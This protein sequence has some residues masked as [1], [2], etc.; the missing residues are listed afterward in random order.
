MAWQDI[1]TT[2]VDAKSPL[3]DQLLGKIRGNLYDLD[4]RVI[5]A[6]NKL[7]LFELQG[8]L[9]YLSG[10][11]RS[12]CAS[13]INDAFTPARVRWVLKKS[14]TSGTLAFDV[15][16][17]TSPNTPITE[18]AHQYNAATQSIAQTGSA[19]N[20][21]SIA[22]FVS[23]ISTQ[24]ITHAKAAKN[25][26][27]IILLGYVESLGADCVQ[28]NLDATI[29][30]DTVVGDSFVAASASDSNNNGT[31]VIVEK[32][33]GGGA[34]VV[35]RNAAG[36][37]Q[38]GAAGTIQEKIMSYNFTNPVSSTGFVAG[39]AHDFASHTSSANDGDL[40]VY[41]INQ[42]GNN[43]WVKN[44]VGVTQGGVAGTVDTNFW[45]FA[46]SGAASTT[47]YIVGEYAKTASHS[48]G[49]NNAGA[50]KIIAV[51][52]GGNNL[53]LY[54]TLGVVQAGV[55]GNINTN[56]WTYA[57]PSDPSAQVTAGDTMYMLGHTNSLNDGTFTIKEVN[58]SASN[59]VVVYNE[60]GVAQGGT[61]GNVYTTRKLVKFSSDQSAV[62]ATSSYVEL[63]GCVDSTYNYKATRAPY[64]VLQVN[65]GGGANFN[66]VIDVPT[67]AAQASPAGRVHL[68]MRSLFNT[69]PSFSMSVTG[70]EPNQNVTGTS[71]DL[72]AS[73]I[74]AGTPLHLYIT[75]Y[76]SGDPR[77]LTIAFI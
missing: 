35:I 58:R 2:E 16:K 73:S 37:A 1:A 32:N 10:H 38:T 29:D 63:E 14:G 52:S 60:S 46:L 48:S 77:D 62:Y 11:Y 42:S 8:R 17:H 19:L 47:D 18:I 24:S 76:P 69:A 20:T 31:F 67:G 64:R 71:T 56:R 25:I 22:R 30:S 43:I 7:F 54:N 59:N 12:I 53:V 51:N 28:Y 36:V 27:S 4:S 45:T 33:R 50:L 9:S 26:Q 66:I 44:P 21:Q 41:A 61:T 55:A 5:A 15:R 6:G 34:N 49:G 72:I 65:R 68:E 75:S 23:Q 74:A 3:D 40:L 70:S 57:L 39:Y 13:I